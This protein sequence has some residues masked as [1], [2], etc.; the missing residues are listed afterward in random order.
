MNKKGF[1]YAVS[2]PVAILILMTLPYLAIVAFGQ[3]ILL[4]VRFWDPVEVFRGY[5][6]AF[7]YELNREDLDQSKAPA[8]IVGDD[9]QDFFKLR[10]RVFYAVLKKGEN[11]CYE[12]DH[13]ASQKP[14]GK[15]YLNCGFTHHYDGKYFF[16]YKLTQKYFVPERKGA[17][18]ERL[19]WE[20][21]QENQYLRAKVKIWNGSSVL[22]DIS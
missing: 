15:L 1:L 12:I 7:D 21:S 13:I 16:D 9:R 22:V 8:E 4:E 19:L 17:E 14:S 3:G 5:Y 10:Q 6:V 11:G 18:L 2:L 20:G